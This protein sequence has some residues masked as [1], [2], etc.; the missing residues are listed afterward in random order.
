[1]QHLFTINCWMELIGSGGNKGR[2][3]RRGT[4]SVM[5]CRLWRVINPHKIRKQTVCLLF[6]CRLVYLRSLDCCVLEVNGH[7]CASD[8]CAEIATKYIDL[9]CGHWILKFVNC[10]RRFRCHSCFWED[11]FTLCLTI[12]R[13]V[14]G[15]RFRLLVTPV[16][17]HFNISGSAQLSHAIRARPGS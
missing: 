9:Q 10:D 15:R 14:F 3:S 1:M 6:G 16:T 12:V 5:F 4:V 11:C 13:P 7:N 8:C 2:Q 17:R